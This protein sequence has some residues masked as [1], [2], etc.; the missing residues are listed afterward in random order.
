MYKPKHACMRLKYVTW[1]VDN[2]LFDAADKRTTTWS[3]TT[4][5]KLDRRILQ[6]T[7]IKIGHTVTRYP[8]DEFFFRSQ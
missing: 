2:Q 5:T 8:L 3:P 4:K 6:H 1:F 7:K